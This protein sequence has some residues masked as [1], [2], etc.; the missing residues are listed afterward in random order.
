MPGAL[1]GAMADAA[2]PH[3]NLLKNGA[4]GRST[5][6]AHA[7]CMRLAHRFPMIRHA[8][9]LTALALS[10]LALPATAQTGAGGVFTIHNDTD[11]N[12]LIGFYVSDDM[13]TWSD[14]WLTDPMMPGESSEAQ[15]FADSGNCVNYFITGW[16][17]ADHA[18]EVLDDPIEVDICQASN[19]YLGNNEIY[20]D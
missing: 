20:F 13:E 9:T 10:L 3:K 2:E 19:L 6:G 4:F 17:G 5:I 12:V 8:L 18:S 1:P 14:N 7:G 11:E 15:F 16:L